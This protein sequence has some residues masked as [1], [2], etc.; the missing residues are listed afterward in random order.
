MVAKIPSFLGH[1]QWLLLY[2]G[3]IFKISNKPAPLAADLKMLCVHVVW[4]QHTMLKEF[5]NRGAIAM[6]HSDELA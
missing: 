3:F 6:L 4:F 2:I 1:S 5:I